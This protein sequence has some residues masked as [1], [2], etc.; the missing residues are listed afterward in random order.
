MVGGVTAENPQNV[1]LAKVLTVAAKIRHMQVQ[2]KA[3]TAE[4]AAAGPE[5]QA[6][7]A[8]KELAKLISA[9]LELQGHVN[10]FMDSAKA[11]SGPNGDG[12]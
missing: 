7:A 12:E 5:A 6:E 10:G 8:A 1:Q 3:K 4:L 2:D 11:A 9:W